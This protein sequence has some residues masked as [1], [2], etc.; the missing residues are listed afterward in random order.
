MATTMTVHR[1]LN[2]IGGTIIE[3]RSGDHRLL[4]DFGLVYDPAQAVAESA[5]RPRAAY[6][7]HDLIRRGRLPAIDGVFPEAALRAA[8][9]PKRL[10]E[11]YEA[12]PALQTLVAVSHLHLD[13]MAAMGWVAPEIPV[14]LSAASLELYQAL[15]AIGEG[16][17]PRRPYDGVPYEAPIAHGPITVTFVP[18]DHDVYG[19]A[20]LFIETPDVRIVYTGDF[21]AHGAHPEVTEAFFDKARAFDPDLLLIEGTTIGPRDALPDDAFRVDAPRPTD[22]KTEAEVQAALAEAFAEAR[23]LVVVNVYPRNLD[24]LAALIAAAEAAE[25]TVLFDPAVAELVRRL[26]GVRPHVYVPDPDAPAYGLPPDVF[27]AEWFRALMADAIRID[28]KAIGAHPSRYVLQNRWEYAFD[29]LDLP[30]EGGLYVHSNGT[31]LGP[32]DPQYA[33]LK[34]FVAELGMDDVVIGTGGHAAPPDLLRAVE[35]ICADVVVPIHSLHPERL[36]VRAPQAFMPEPGRT[37][38]LNR[39]VKTV[40]T[41]DCSKRVLD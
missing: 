33:R 16:A 4:F 36:A 24:R 26:I 2:T 5:I 28:A 38:A 13:H 10:P 8:G 14:V 29:L 23:G 18:I 40:K 1:G 35:R 19:A 37:Y 6:A 32:F 22:I 3:V 7:L 27:S 15:E 31:P 41:V 11:P 12:L 9:R 34:S 39:T 30:T 21:R 20:G 25:R 17:V